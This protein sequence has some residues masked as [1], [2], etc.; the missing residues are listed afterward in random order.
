[1]LIIGGGPGGAT[2]A[3]F[4]IREGIKP[5]VLEQET[6]PRFH[7]GVVPILNVA[8]MPQLLGMVACTHPR[9]R[10]NVEEISSTKIETALA[11]G[12]MDVRFGF[13]HP[14]LIQPPLGGSLH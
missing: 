8:L 2:A 14:P 7:V 13:P 4:L 3:M 1:V 9:I 5:I 11:E 6:F 12:R 10:L